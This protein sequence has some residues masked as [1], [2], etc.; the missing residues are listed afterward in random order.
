MSSPAA[1]FVQSGVSVGLVNK[2]ISSGGSEEQLSGTS[3]MALLRTGL[4]AVFGLTGTISSSLEVPAAG[5]RIPRQL[6][7]GLTM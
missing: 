4:D 1:N 5:A 2:T 7:E 6:V 3:V